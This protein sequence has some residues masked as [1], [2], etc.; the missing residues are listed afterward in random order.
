MSL[1]VFALIV[2]ST[3]LFL[4]FLSGIFYIIQK[5]QIIINRKLY[6]IQKKY[7]ITSINDYLNNL[8]KSNIYGSILFLLGFIV[9][10]YADNNRYPYSGV[11]LIIYATFVNILIHRFERKIKK[12]LVDKNTETI[13]K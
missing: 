1:Y 7:S 6:R 5:P 3:I 11:I 10:I 12:Y 4:Y 13:D 8:G 9:A 2:G